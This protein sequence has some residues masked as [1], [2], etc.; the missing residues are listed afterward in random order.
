MRVDF[1]I[2]N[3]ALKDLPASGPV[4]NPKAKIRN[5]RPKAGR[6]SPMAAL[7]RPR[8]SFL[9]FTSSAMAAA[10]PIAIAFGRP[11]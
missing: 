10:I 3:Q 9:A 7:K 1:G 11:A 2:L 6:D 8:A 5:F 4:M